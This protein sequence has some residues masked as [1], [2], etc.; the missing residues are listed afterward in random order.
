MSYGLIVTSPDDYEVIAWAQDLNY[1][2]GE[3][4]DQGYSP[5]QIENLRVFELSEPKSYHCL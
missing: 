5:E 2:L 3:L 1:L 4:T